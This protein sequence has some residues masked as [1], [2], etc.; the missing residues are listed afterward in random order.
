M[1]SSRKWSPL[2]Q[3]ATVIASFV[4]IATPAPLVATRASAQDYKPADVSKRVRDTCTPDARRLCPNQPLGSSAM[5]Y[6]ME[7]RARSISRDC[8][9]ALEDDGVVPRGH[10]RRGP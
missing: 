10:F 3:T 4:T 1:F 6:C 9:V 8:K 2:V 5:V 7:S